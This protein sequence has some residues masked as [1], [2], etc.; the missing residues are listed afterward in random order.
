MKIFP[1]ILGF[2]CLA[3]FLS[4]VN[5]EDFSEV[6][7][8]ELRLLNGSGHESAVR[9]ATDVNFDVTGMVA[10][11][12]LTQRFKNPGNEFLEGI[13]VFPL[14]DDAAVNH[15]EVLVG[16][17]RIVGEIKEKSEAKL[18][19]RKARSEGKRASLVTQAR[20]NLFR[21]RV[22]N[23]P[24][25]S[26]VEVVLTLIQPVTYDSG[27]FS[28][29]FPLAITPRYLPGIPLSQ[30]VSVEDGWG[31]PTTK[32]KDGHLITPWQGP[33]ELHKLS[34]SGEVKAGVQLANYGSSSHQINARTTAEG[35]RFALA[36]G[37]G[38]HRD[39]EL[40]WRPEPSKSPVAAYFTETV[41]DEDFGFLMLM[42]PQV[43]APGTGLPVSRLP[44]E[45]TFIIDTSGSMGGASIK[46]AKQSLLYSLEQ[47]AAD[48]TFNIVEFNASFQPLFDQ[49]QQANAMNL[50]QA[51]QF[52]ARLSAGGGTEML[53]A[54]DFALSRANSERLRQIVF[55]TD[56]AVGNE[57]ELFQLIYDRLGSARLFTVGIGSAPNSYF[58]RTA[59]TFGRG[60]Y[61]KVSSTHEVSAVMSRLFDKLAKPV[62][63]DIEVDWP[64][65]WQVFPEYAGDLYAGEPLLIA[66]KQGRQID[67]LTVRG[68][69]AAYPWEQ[70]LE[71]HAPAQGDGVATLWARSKL[72]HILDQKYR[73]VDDAV[74]RSEA[75]KLALA[76]KIMSPYTSFVAVEEYVTR[77][78][79]NAL[80]TRS[81]PGP[82]PA[83]QTLNVMMP[84]TSTGWWLYVITGVLLSL[85]FLFRVRVQ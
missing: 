51:K 76:H 35:W 41:A 52:V 69:T 21:N 48:D 34:L 44:R 39:F 50:Y 10:H 74:I 3:A 5:A 33:D 24:P 15:L 11:I 49:A 84:Q 25:Q 61:T 22:A 80:Q 73:G 2:A 27:R 47:L 56:G 32:V 54:L 82:V 66:V 8:G 13:Y 43:N 77:P 7:S 64:E 40:F 71:L 1:L 12:K 31:V 18:I 36:P 81:V 78:A 83:G 29:H 75:L 20:P 58:M 42:P 57:T 70:T 19:Y 65:D 59:A 4:P 30:Q 26:E 38:V 6:S 17:R 55:I 85:C 68:V 37:A 14:P 23:I 9:L 46:Q 45:M 16:D 72:N 63:R 53:P 79:G 67:R 28:I 60:S 62:A